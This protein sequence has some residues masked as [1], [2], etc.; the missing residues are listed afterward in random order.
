MPLV[1][2]LSA[3]SLDYVNFEHFVLG[4]AVGTSSVN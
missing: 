2:N 1:V 4:T 3:A